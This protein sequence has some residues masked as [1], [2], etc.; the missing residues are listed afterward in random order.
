M[1]DPLLV[2]ETNVCLGPLVFEPSGSQALVQRELLS[3][4]LRHQ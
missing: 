2:N 4:L 3:R 1:I